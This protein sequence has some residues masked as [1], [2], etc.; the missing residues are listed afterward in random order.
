M[1]LFRNYRRNKKGEVLGVSVK[2]CFKPG[3]IPVKTM[4]VIWGNIRNKFH[5]YK[6]LIGVC[7]LYDTSH[8]LHCYKLK[9]TSQV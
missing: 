5:N 3:V 1:V 8:K 4:D 7:L 6:G 9:S 2:S